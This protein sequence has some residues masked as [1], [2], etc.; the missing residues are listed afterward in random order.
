MTS[1]HGYKAQ[2]DYVEL[3]VEHRD[4]YWRLILN[5]AKHGERVEHEEKFGSAAD[6]QNAAL[7]AARRHIY[8]QHNDTL[9]ARRT[10]AWTEY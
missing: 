4:D 9:L 5:D 8:E 1:G 2:Y 7:S 6:A 10:L 3:L